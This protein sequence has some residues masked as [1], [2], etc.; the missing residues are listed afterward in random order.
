MNCNLQD[1]IFQMRVAQKYW[2]PKTKEILSQLSDVAQT[3][4][5]RKFKSKVTRTKNGRFSE[6]Y[7]ECIW[8]NPYAKD[9]PRCCDCTI[10]GSQVY[11]FIELFQDISEEE[12]GLPVHETIIRRLYGFECNMNCNLQDIIIQLRDSERY[13]TPKTKKILSE[14]SDIAEAVEE[15]KLQNKLTRTENGRFGEHY[16]ECVWSN[17]YAE[18]GPRSCVC[19]TIGSLMY[20]FIGLFKDIKVYEIGVSQHEELFRKLHGFEEED[21]S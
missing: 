21:V 8:S 12:I 19:N 15:M 4:Q 5:E 14:M 2:T 17:P 13:R 20:R 6:H 10:I 16:Y 18:D 1:I 3:V 7:Y 11:R 9:G